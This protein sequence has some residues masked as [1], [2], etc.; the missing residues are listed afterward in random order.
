MRNMSFAYTTEQVRRQEKTLT[1]RFGWW[2]LKP[3]DLVQPVKKCMGLKKGEKMQKIGCPIRIVRTHA[4]PFLALTQEEVGAEGFPHLSV[5]E[6]VR[7]ISKTM[8]FNPGKICNR[9]RF[10]YTEQIREEKT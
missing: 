2:F 10:E 5:Q 3:G 8:K 6:F 7:H 4:E 9:I 1:S